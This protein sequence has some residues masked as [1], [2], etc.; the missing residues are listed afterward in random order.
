[1]NEQDKKEFEKQAAEILRSK[2]L[3]DQ[4]HL[5]D[6]N[7][8]ALSTLCGKPISQLKQSA[9]WDEITCEP[10]KAVSRRIVAAGR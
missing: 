9:I 8:D 5:A 3:D 4:V 10:C 1:M 6:S 2:N 7:K